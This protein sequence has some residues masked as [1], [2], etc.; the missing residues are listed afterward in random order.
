MP[1]RIDWNGIE[2]KLGKTLESVYFKTESSDETGKIFGAIIG[3]KQGI[4]GMAVLMEL[5]KRGYKINPRGGAN[6]K[7]TGKVNEYYKK[8][9]ALPD[10]PA[11]KMVEIC[12]R[13]GL[14]QTHFYSTLDKKPFEYNR[15]RQLDFNPFINK[16]RCQSLDELFL[17][18][19]NQCFNTKAVAKK[20]DISENAAYLRLRKL[21]VYDGNKRGNKFKIKPIR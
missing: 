4:S 11:L 9:I 15:R 17:L 6:Y 18:L 1:N 2:R 5:H 16:Y 19:W 7:G 10:L 12:A 21:N 20:L 13:T 3:L 14:T 8:I